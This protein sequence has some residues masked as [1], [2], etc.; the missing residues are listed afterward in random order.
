M[1]PQSFYTRQMLLQY[2]KQMIA[3]RRLARY[4][5]LTGRRQRIDDDAALG[6]RRA[7]VERI[8]REI[9]ENL[10]FSGSENPIVLEV[11]KS[12]ERE[13]GQ[14]YVFRYPPAEE[15]FLILRRTPEGG[16]EELTGEERERLMS[17]LWDVSLRV[18]N[19]T[20]L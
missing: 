11:R 5:R 10:L 16:E 6:R 8:A 17:R 4:E 15:D 20:M 3:A 7:L 14:E 19:A 2:G 18:V 9:I 1:D 13:T 12:L